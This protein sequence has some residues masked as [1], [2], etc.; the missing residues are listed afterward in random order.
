MGDALE[1]AHDVGGKDFSRRVVWG[2]CVDAEH[3]HL[4]CGYPVGCLCAQTA[5]LGQVLQGVAVT[6]PV[7]GVEQ[8]D[9]ALA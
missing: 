9:I 1:L 6:T 2:W 4:V 8:Q 3:L 5:V 7:P